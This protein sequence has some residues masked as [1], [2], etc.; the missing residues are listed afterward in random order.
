MTTNQR[1]VA[2]RTMT[3]A[4]NIKATPITLQNLSTLGLC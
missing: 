1:A 2:Q 4:D 3:S